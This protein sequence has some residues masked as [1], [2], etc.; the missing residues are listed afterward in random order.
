M[1][2]STLIFDDLLM[3]FISDGQKLLYTE[4]IV[5]AKYNPLMIMR[6]ITTFRAQELCESRGGRPGLPVPNSSYDL[7]G[8]KAT[9]KT[10]N[11]IL[12]V[13]IMEICKAPTL[14]LIA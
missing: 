7:C 5:I 10:K 3:I 12:L 4:L 1:G 11:S 2:S 14:L 8:R 13:I 9:L 6:R